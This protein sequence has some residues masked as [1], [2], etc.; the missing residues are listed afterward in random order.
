[1]K[2]YLLATWFTIVAALPHGFGATLTVTNLADSGPGTLRDRLAASADGDRIEFHVFGT[3]VLS[4]ELT[5][6]KSVVIAGPGVPFLKI[7]GNQATRL[8]HIASGAPGINSLC[9]CDGRVSGTNGAVGRNGESVMGGA[10]FI[11]SGAS[12]GM[13]TVVISNNAVVG[14]QGGAANPAGSSGNGGKGLGGAIANL[15][16][17]TLVVALVSGN[18][19][20]GGGGGPASPSPGAAGEGWGGAIYSEGRANITL[21]T[22]NN[23]KA[24]AGTGVG[25]P[26]RGV[27][28][29]IYSMATLA[30]FVSTVASNSAGG[31]SSDMGGGIFGSGPIFLGDLTI[32]G[33][34]ADVGGGLSG[35]A[36]LGN[37]ILAGNTAGTGPDGN[38]NIMSSDYNLIQQTNG[39]TIAGA[40]AHN[41]I[42]LDPLLTP[43][44]DNGG[45]DVG[46]ALVTMVPLP[47]SPV[48]D[49]G[50]SGNSD[51]RAFQRPFDTCIPNASGGN[52]SDIGAVE[53]L[54]PP[55]RLNIQL[56]KNDVLLS[57]STGDCGFVLQCLTNMNDEDWSQV[58]NPPVIQGAQ[59]VVTN[60]VV[61]AH[62][63]YRLAPP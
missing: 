18:S 59:F 8:F 26:G 34:D 44:Q 20:S 48:I 36:D 29:G 55:P 37:S 58:A 30:A 31:S 40:T 14:G 3:I 22:I 24:M 38:G 53:F 19:A 6:S 28:G 17:L 4:N 16:Q 51:E 9:L 49:Q 13:S 62:K 2:P 47:G 25:A 43:L 11:A 61:G 45:Y 33:N 1:M 32:V 46:F 42:G 35:A 60:P 7:S 54:P 56:A 12:L 15:G 63:F 39:L 27:G 23:N 10:I 50:K 5:V 21:C 52:G 41:L 57:W